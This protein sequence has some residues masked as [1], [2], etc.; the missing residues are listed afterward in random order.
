MGLRGRRP[1]SGDP[2]ALSCVSS[3][4][5]PALCMFRW[6]EGLQLR[7]PTCSLCRAG[8]GRTSQVLP[9]LRSPGPDPDKEDIWR[10]DSDLPSVVRNPSSCPSFVM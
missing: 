1:R 7:T 6:D 10:V 8:G 4:P 5:P 3:S 9:W 2:F